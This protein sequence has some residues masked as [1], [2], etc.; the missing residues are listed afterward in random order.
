[1][2]DRRRFG[3]FQVAKEEYQLIRQSTGTI[4][5]IKDLNLYGLSYEYISTNTQ[6]FEFEDIGIISEKNRGAFLPG[7]SC[8]VIYDI[9]ADEKSDFYSAIQF[10][11]RGLKYRKLIRG[12]MDRLTCLLNGLNDKSIENAIQKIG[13]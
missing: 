3:R 11:R 12:Q 10:R 2:F 13:K 8:K 1:M 5:W 6:Q 4:G 9:S 7:I